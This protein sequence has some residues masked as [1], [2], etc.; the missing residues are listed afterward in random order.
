LHED[1]G[2]LLNGRMLLLL[3]LLAANDSVI[4]DKQ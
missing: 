2:E 1:D 4:G 3:L